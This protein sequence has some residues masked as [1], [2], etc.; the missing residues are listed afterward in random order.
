MMLRKDLVNLIK[1]STCEFVVVLVF[2]VTIKNESPVELVL[3]STCESLCFFS[4]KNIQ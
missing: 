3:N 1:R 4:N 2:V